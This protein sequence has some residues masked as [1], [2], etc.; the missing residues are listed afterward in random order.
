MYQKLI[1]FILALHWAGLVYGQAYPEEV[2]KTKKDYGTIEI[3]DFKS[4]KDF[5]GKAPEVSPTIDTPGSNGW[6]GR[7]PFWISLGLGNRISPEELEDFIDYNADRGRPK[8]GLNGQDVYLSLGANLVTN[9]DLSLEY[10]QTPTLTVL[11]KKD[12]R[13][14]YT[15]GE[16]TETYSFTDDRKIKVVSFQILAI[17]TFLAFNFGATRIYGGYAWR[18]VFPKWYLKPQK[19]SKSAA[20][21]GFF[22][23][24]LRLGLGYFIGNFLPYIETGE[25][26]ALGMR[27]YF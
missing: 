24:V 16:P 11:G 6:K 5:I 19:T 12:E 14:S 21:A 7:R 8:T 18:Q 3:S 15:I 22:S 13:F 10:A 23:S 25:S 9:L 4:N 2:S 1:G 20:E 26:T 17:K 27:Y